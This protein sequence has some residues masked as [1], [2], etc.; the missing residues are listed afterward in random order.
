MGTMKWI[1]IVVVGTIVFTLAGCRSLP[2]KPIPGSTQVATAG[3]STT[4]AAGMSTSSGRGLSAE[5]PPPVA[6]LKSSYENRA[7]YF[8]FNKSII[9][10]KYFSL[11]KNQANYLLAHTNTKVLLEGY[12]D[13]RGT[14]GYNIGLGS[15][16]AAAV[17]NFLLLQGV[18]PGQVKTISYGEAY[19][20][21]PANNPSAW[22][23]NRR[24]IINYT[25]GKPS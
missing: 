21:D 2:S 20:A 10:P 8:A 12:T 11:L 9:K 1:G 7:V 15:R 24:V 5:M 3:A 16:R 14:W 6:G 22:T 18:T 17:E 23:K 19:P 4:G 25:V 13:D